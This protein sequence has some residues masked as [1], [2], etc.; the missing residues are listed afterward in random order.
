MKYVYVYTDLY[1]KLHSELG[2][3]WAKEMKQTKRTK[4]C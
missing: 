3:L 4:T 2:R 1:M